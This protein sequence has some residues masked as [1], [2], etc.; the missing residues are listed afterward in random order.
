MK[1]VK[2][3]P[4]LVAMACATGAT[5]TASLKEGEIS[6]LGR[7]LGSDWSKVAP[8][9]VRQLWPTIDLRTEAAGNGCEGSVSLT[10]KTP[11]SARTFV[12]NRKQTGDGCVEQLNAISFELRVTEPKRR[13]QIGERI[14]AMVAQST[15]EA[16]VDPNGYTVVS[17]PMPNI[18]QTTRFS[19]VG[20][21]VRF[22]IFRVHLER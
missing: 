11:D 9:R 10:Q 12:F 1:A 15:D 7:L 3:L 16:R 5:T 17:W 22:T 21:E 19:T 14:N 8:A 4:M 20:E 13:Q 2:L 18:N 6:A